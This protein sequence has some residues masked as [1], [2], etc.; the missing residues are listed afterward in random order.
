MTVVGFTNVG[1]SADGADAVGGLMFIGGTTDG[2]FISTGAAVCVG[3]DVVQHS[4]KIPDG[5]GQQTP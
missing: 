3:S 4:K 2:G 1:A 5:V